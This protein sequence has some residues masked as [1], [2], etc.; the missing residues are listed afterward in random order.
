[1]DAVE[2]KRE[3][4]KGQGQRRP[5]GRDEQLVEVSAVVLRA[6]GED[7][8]PKTRRCCDY[9]SL[10][11]LTTQ[12]EFAATLCLSRGASASAA[13]EEE[14]FIQI[15]KQTASAKSPCKGAESEC[16]EK[17]KAVQSSSFT[18]HGR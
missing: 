18:F 13:R 16:A 6:F 4:R 2:R 11:I 10:S 14:A 8:Y 17:R 15:W 1:M 5:K 7:R 3:E 9:L 12:V